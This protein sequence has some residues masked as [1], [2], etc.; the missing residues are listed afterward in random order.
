[1]R[2]Q[3]WIKALFP[4]PGYFVEAGAHDGVGDSATKELED[5]G[6]TGICVEPSSAFHGLKA[7][8]KCKVDD[9]CLWKAG[10]VYVRFQE[11]AGEGIELSGIEQ[12]FCDHHD[13]SDGQAVFKRTVCLP[14]LLRHHDAPKVIEFLSLDT[15]GSEYEILFAHDFDAYRF[16]AITVEHNGVV[17]RRDAI[18]TLLQGHGYK[19][20]VSTEIEDWFIHEEGPGDGD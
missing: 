16:L 15:E 17:E 19:V 7:S 2:V 10:E 6:W 20:D 9:R 11:V 5:I 1:M 8:R 13:R 12:C 14:A 3:D 18:R 4:E